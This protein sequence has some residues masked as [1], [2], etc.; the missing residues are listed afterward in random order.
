MSGQFHYGSQHESAAKSAIWI[1]SHEAKSLTSSSQATGKCP[2]DCDT[3]LQ[4]LREGKSED[5][6]HGQRDPGQTDTSDSVPQG[7]RG[8]AVPTGVCLCRRSCPAGRA[9]G[10]SACRFLAGSVPGRSQGQSDAMV[11]CPPI[12]SFNKWRRLPK[13]CCAPGP[14]PTERCSVENEAGEDPVL[15]GR[16][17]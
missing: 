7:C 13:T 8:Q 6:E 4:G 1:H 11:F 14:G 16:A 5:T 9:S 15:T 2:I 10:R 17:F 12:H 3:R